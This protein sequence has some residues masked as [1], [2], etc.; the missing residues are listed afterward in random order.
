MH[1]KQFYL[2]CLAH[3]SYFIE[4]NGEAAVVDPQRDIQQYLDEAEKTGSRIRY[5]IE[6]HLHADFVSGHRELAERTGAEIVFGAAANAEVMHR[7]VNDGDELHVGAVTL[8][9]ME[10][11]G[12]TPE[13]V[14]WL[15][16]GDDGTERVLTGDTLFI[17]DVG[18]PDLAGGRGFTPEQMAGLLY[19]SLHRKLL[20][21]HDGVEVWPAHG[22]G[23]ACGKNIS[24]ER[25]STIGAQRLAN[26]ALQP[27][28]KEAFV[29][30]MTTDLPPAPRY[31]PI[32]A[33]INRRGARP[34]SEVH[35]PALDPAE[36]ERQMQQG[37]LVLDVRDAFLFGTAHL[38]GSINIGLRGQ[39][40]SW[41]GT[42]VETEAPLLIV[43]SGR[44]EAEEAIMRLARV[45]LENVAG[46][47]EGGLAAW[48]DSGRDVEELAQIDVAELHSRLGEMIV[49][50]VRRRGEYGGGHVPHAVNVP[51]D[52]LAPSLGALDPSK[53]TAIICASGYRSSTAAS[54][55]QRNEFGAQLFN[56][57]GGTGAWMAA[58]Y[59]T[60]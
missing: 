11:P 3:A 22:A 8:R 35:A 28:A 51:L 41:A 16:A 18:R 34:L 14:S 31:F 10:T 32:D 49:L 21:L 45:G 55:L 19:D 47:L 57:T 30:M 43:A 27:M 5:V 58:G 39:Y 60:E 52:E 26:Y 12:H 53:P 42:L 13:S 44:E 54:L 23:S 25:S 2:G 9:A 50:D 33:E 36:F 38:R 20:K 37:A 4:S 15:V 59:E 29:K 17:G 6:T 1:F 7:A 40:A 46:W 24:R 48:C 56:V